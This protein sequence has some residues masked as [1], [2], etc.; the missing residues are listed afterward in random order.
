VPL[1]WDKIERFIQSQ[2]Q[3]LNVPI[4]AF[5]QS[6]HPQASNHPG[7][8]II[9]DPNC[10][11]QVILLESSLVIGLPVTKETLKPIT[12]II[13]DNLPKLARHYHQKQK[14]QLK[15]LVLSGIEERK[16][17]LKDSIQQSEYSLE[18]LNREMF[19]LSRKRELDKTVLSH[20]EKPIIQPARKI[21]SEYSSLKKLVPSLYQEI[22]FEDN[23]VRAKT[24]PVTISYEG[25]DYD[26]GTLVIEINL[27]RGQ[28]KIVNLNNAA[29]GYPHPHVNESGEICLGNISTGL[30]R[31]LGEFEIY[32]ALDLLH[33][34]VHTYNEPDAYQKIQYWDDPDYCEEDDEYGRCRSGGSYGRVCLDC[35]DGD[36]PYYE[37]AIEECSEEPDFPKCVNCGERCSAGKELLSDCH[38]ENP[39]GCMT[40]SFS[41]CPHFRDSNSCRKINSESCKT[42]NIDYCQYRGVD[43]EA[44]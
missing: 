39:L 25:D 16:S 15:R 11:N 6:N 9:F 37:N 13:E 10:Q 5:Q 23:T 29:N 18:S 3:K 26:I 43:Y 8:S 4:R 27:S 22:E 38:N 31:M 19:E 24:Y 33:K 17:S 7:I 36:C 14:D 2:A 20:L 41:S 34:F 30:A 1:P 42:C 21:S 32:G 44:A 40:C 35:G 12:Q 28:A